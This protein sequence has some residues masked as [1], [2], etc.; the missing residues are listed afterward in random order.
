MPKVGTLGLDMM[1]R[2]STVQVNLDFGPDE[3]T[4]AKRYLAS[5][6]MAPFSGAVFN[7]S[8]FSEQKPVGMTGLRSKV[9]RHLDPSRTG[10]PPLAGLSRRL[11]KEACVQTYFDFLMAA[12]VVFVTD[13][14]YKVMHEPLTWADWMKNGVDGVYPNLEDFDT[15]LSLLFPEVRARGFLELRSVDCQSRVWQFAPAAWWTGLLYDATACDQVIEMLLPLAGRMTELLDAAPLGLQHPV[16]KEGAHK[17][18]TT[19]EEG[20]SRLAECYCGEGVQRILHI[21]AERFTWRGRVP[22]D[23]VLDAY[24][25]RGVLTQDCFRR[26]EDQWRQLIEG[27]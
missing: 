16:L 24:R 22:A 13:L 12:R 14:D 1:Y 18:M 17:L 9:W 6:L 3:A 10:V 11:T 2:T 7:Y 15:H 27:S 21:F 25:Q 26:T 20:L 19:A 8:A 4:M 23:D 5:I